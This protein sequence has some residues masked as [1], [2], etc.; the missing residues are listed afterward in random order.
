M[1]HFIIFHPCLRRQKRGSNI[2]DCHLSESLM[3]AAALNTQIKLLVLPSA[4]WELRVYHRAKWISSPGEILHAYL[5]QEVISS[6]LHHSIYRLQLLLHIFCGLFSIAAHVLEWITLILSILLLN[7]AQ[8]FSLG[9]RGSHRH[10]L[11]KQEQ[12]RLGGETSGL[13]N[14]LCNWQNCKTFKVYNVTIWYT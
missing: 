4:I 1:Y 10:F 6:A 5:P 12:M 11:F 3:K 14:S 9:V 7:C 8:T 13:W 2:I